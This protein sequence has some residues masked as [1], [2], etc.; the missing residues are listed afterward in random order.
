MDGKAI[1]GSAAGGRLAGQFPKGLPRRETI[2]T[3]SRLLDAFVRK[4][5]R[6]FEARAKMR[7]EEAAY[8]QEMVRYVEEWAA[9]NGGR[10]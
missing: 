3:R 10:M 4:R 1:S 7:E 2:N 8:Q 6:A 9:E 5:D